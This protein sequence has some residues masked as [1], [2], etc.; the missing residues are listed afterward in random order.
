MTQNVQKCYVPLRLCAIR[1][2]LLT[3]DGHAQAGA[4][5]AYVS[6]KPVTLGINPAL[7]AA[8]TKSLL[9]GC[10]DIVAYATKP[11]LM[12]GFT[13]ALA[14]AGLEPELEALLTG[15][16]AIFDDSAIPVAVGYNWPD[17]TSG[18]QSP[19]VA[20]EAWTLN[21]DGNAQASSP[22]RYK[23]F[24]FPM[25]FWQWDNGT[26]QDDFFTSGLQATTQGNPNWAYGPYSDVPAGYTAMGRS[27]GY[28]DEDYFPTASCGYISAGS[29]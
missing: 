14:K 23:R 17:D 4:N 8:D 22:F 13:M 3:A 27:G 2:T 12:T 5:T 28:I 19:P 7:I 20:F 29:S 21:W 26:L 16:P 24:V 25:T 1:A 15:S 9:N 6:N 18:S 10:G 11:A